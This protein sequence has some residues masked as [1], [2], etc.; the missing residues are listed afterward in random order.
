MPSFLSISLSLSL[1]SLP[2]HSIPSHSLLSL[3]L[4]SFLPSFSSLPLIALLFFPSLSFPPLSSSEG[5]SS[6][7][8]SV[9]VTAGVRE[10]ELSVYHQRCCQGSKKEGMVYG[11]VSSSYLYFQKYL[12]SCRRELEVAGE[13]RRTNDLPLL[14]RKRDVAIKYTLCHHGCTDITQKF[15]ISQDFWEIKCVHKH[16]RPSRA[17]VQGYCTSNCRLLYSL[18]CPATQKKKRHCGVVWCT[19]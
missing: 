2:L 16:G 7:R 18:W 6:S 3:P 15:P 11:H 14:V 5:G 9:D 17:W 4:C 10:G 12:Y 19:V 1:S 8:L 13:C